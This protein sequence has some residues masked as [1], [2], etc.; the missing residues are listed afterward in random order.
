[1]PRPERL[2]TRE[3]VVAP[4]R[5]SCDAVVIG[6]GAGGAVVAAEL[7][8]AG[9]DVIVLEEGGYHPTEEFVAEPAQMVR[10]LYRDGGASMAIGT[11]AISFA[12]GRCVGGSTVING[13]MSWRTP[14]KVLERW[15]REDMVDGIRAA[16]M[17]RAFARVEKYVSARPQ[18]PESASRDN[19]ILRTGAERKG[20][21]LV[22]NI[23]D[24]LHCAGTNNCAFG[25]PTA[26]KRSTLVSYL[27]RALGFGARV[28]AD[29]R[30]DRIVFH[31]KRATGVRAHAVRANGSRGPEITVRADLVVVCAGAI[32]TPTLLIRS[33]VRS[34]SRQ[35]GRNLT[36]H[37]NAKVVAIF[38]ENVEGWKG[39]HQA[40]QVREFQDEGFIMAAV[41]VPPSVIAMTLPQYGG[42]LG[43]IIGHYNRMVMAGI[44]VE[45]TVSGRVRA[46]PGPVDVPPLA[47]YQLS[48]FD[49]ERIVRG[50][51]LLAELLFAAGAR[52]IILPFDGAPDLHDADDVRR[53]FARK[54]PKRALE[55]M[56][57]H[58]MGTARMG[59]DRT[60]HVCD[61]WGK[62]YDT[63]GLYVADA[64]LFPSPIGVNP[65]ETIM[66]L[67]TR[68]AEHLL[69]ERAARRGAA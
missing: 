37:P 11:P 26:A 24:Q 58:V 40:Y 35:I 39:V 38:D 2:L 52:R 48:D 10:K 1:M 29:C 23:R 57:V 44:L 53:L 46:L 12:E 21:R 15:W 27:P 13:G 17:E 66:A 7:A 31:G 47:F 67:A 36:L 51:A 49:A 65:M 56:T 32:Q 54:I 22:A 14:E 42:A 20:W 68:N 43:E 5:L 25:C 8:E 28:Y 34:P 41:N 9:L 6:S 4:E 3:D 18:D 55:V 69:E 33:G 19:E 62:V 50:T 30:V 16:D 60:R 64:S 59:G 63:A 61:P 45:D